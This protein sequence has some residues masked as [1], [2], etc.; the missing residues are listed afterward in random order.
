MKS[1]VLEALREE[2]REEGRAEGRVEGRV[3]G[4]LE[5]LRAT[6]L[7]MGRK[8]FHRAA[9]RKQQADLNAITDASRLE[10]LS[11]RLLDVSSWSELFARP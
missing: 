11:E 9:S 8:K 3:E 2:V 4:R 6:I 5:A 7:R 1:P 10:A